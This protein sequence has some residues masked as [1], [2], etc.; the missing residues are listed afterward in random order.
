MRPKQRSRGQFISI[1]GFHKVRGPAA[2]PYELLL[3]DRYWRP[4]PHLNEWHRLHGEQLGKGR[5]RATYLDMLLPFM[6][7]LLDKGYGWDAEP[8]A[9]RE[10]TRQFLRSWGCVIKRAWATDG[11]LIQPS[12]LLHPSTLSLFLAAS[13]SFYQTMI[14]GEWDEKHRTRVP[15]YPFDNPMYSPMLRRWKREHLRALASARAPDVAG[16]RGA[17]RAESRSK[18][19]GYFRARGDP[20]QP[21]VAGEAR[22]VRLLIRAAANYMIDHAKLREQLVLRLLSDSGPR[23]REALA[24]TAG[25]LRRAQHPLAAMVRNKGSRGREVK[26][27][28]LTDETEA[29][30]HRYISRERAKLDPLGRRRLDQL[31]DDEPVFLSRR[32]GALSAG[33]FRSQ[34]VKLRK[35]AEREFRRFPVS[36]PHLRPHMLRHLHV[37]EQMELI[38]ELAPNDPE[39]QRALRDALRKHMHWRS[40]ETMQRY[41]HALSTSEAQD[42][43]QQAFVAELTAWPRDRAELQAAVAGDPEAPV[44]RAESAER[45]QRLERL[46]EES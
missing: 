11:F 5:T 33:A 21:P 24:L 34:W 32:G 4:I 19:I 1:A 27:I 17:T 41:D 30:L 39:R 38:C 26:E 12:N 37:T 18:P 10:Y 3:F 23:L 42:L 44:Y 14:E 43:L 28:S 46:I 22:A 29:L 15:L 13:R 20:W 35:K 36:L 8:D 16:I 2:S 9:V 31:A 40:A 45:L 6:G 7:F 25:G